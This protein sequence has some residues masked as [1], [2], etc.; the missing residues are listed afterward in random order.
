MNT[1][2]EDWATLCGGSWITLDSD[3]VDR[4]RE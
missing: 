1:L 2:N 3:E 4:W